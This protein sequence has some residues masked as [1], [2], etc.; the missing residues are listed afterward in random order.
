[1][2]QVD[3]DEDEEGEVGADEDGVEVVECFGGLDG[4]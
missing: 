4:C 3:P 1:M 2:A